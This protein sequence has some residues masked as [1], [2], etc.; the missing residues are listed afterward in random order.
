[1][2]IHPVMSSTPLHSGAGRPRLAWLATQV[3]VL[4]GTVVMIVSAILLMM[5]RN[6]LGALFSSDEE[7]ILLTSQAVPALAVSLIGA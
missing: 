3:S 4:M 6:Q 5:F 1:M 7:V 2:G